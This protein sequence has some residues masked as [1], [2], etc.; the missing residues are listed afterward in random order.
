MKTYYYKV[1]VQT[2]YRKPGEEKLDDKFLCT[3]FK[4]RNKICLSSFGR[5]LAPTYAILKNYC[6]WFAYENAEK[7]YHAN[8]NHVVTMNFFR[9]KI[10]YYLIYIYISYFEKIMVSKML[11]VCLQHILGKVLNFSIKCIVQKSKN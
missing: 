4:C 10:F 7:L 3:F 8:A 6:R 2:L 1:N 11:L 5:R 9:V